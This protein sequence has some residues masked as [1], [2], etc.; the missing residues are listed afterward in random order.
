MSEHLETKYRID[1]LP[2]VKKNHAGARCNL[3]CFWCHNDYFKMKNEINYDYSSQFNMIINVLNSIKQYYPEKTEVQISSA[4]EPTLVGTDN[5]ISL[6]S[7]IKNT[8]KG[9]V[10]LTTNGTVLKAID[11]QRFSDAGLDKVNFSINTLNPDVYRDITGKCGI[12]FLP[13]VLDSIKAASESGISV[14]VNC[15]YSKINVSEL[16]DFLSFIEQTPNIRWKFFDLLGNEK[17]Y[18][19]VSHLMQQ[20]DSRG[21]NGKRLLK[22]HY[23]YYQIKVRKSTVSIKISKET[24]DCPNM[25]CPVRS[26]CN[27]GCRSSIRISSEGI[28]P[29]GIRSDNIIETDQLDNSY[30]VEAKLISGGKLAPREYPNAG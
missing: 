20:L 10:G 22:G 19:P 12:K 1:L 21:F 6:I 9:K 15:V 17:Q 29:C 7:E 11:W 8:V 2:L 26:D 4:G 24:N 25:N 5:L 27:E 16:D 3:N 14:S 23:S 13:K 30:Q 18:L 28:Q